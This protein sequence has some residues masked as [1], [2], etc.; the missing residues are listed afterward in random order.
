MVT[1]LAYAPACATTATLQLALH[2]QM[3]GGT[4]TRATKSTLRLAR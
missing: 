3:A 4:C 1:L 2:A